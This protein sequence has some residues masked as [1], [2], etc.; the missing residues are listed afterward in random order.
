MEAAAR[1]MGYRAMK[2]GVD[3]RLYTKTTPDRIKALAPDAI[4]VA[5]GSEPAMP[6]I[7][8][9][10]L[11]HVYEARKVISGKVRIAAQKVAVIGGGL[12]GLEAA[13]FLAEQ[14][15]TVTVI[16]MLDAIGK[17]L[18]MY[19]YPHMMQ[20]IEDFH[21]DVHVQSKCISI[22]PGRITVEKDGVRK[23]IPADAVVIAAGAKP[24]PEEIFTMASRFT[25]ECHVIGDAKKPGNVINAIWQGHEA[26]RTI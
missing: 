14:G 17:D 6:N 7:P 4:I 20:I 21:I 11:E 5:V 25:K 12:V 13:E 18:E 10:E 24:D 16:E 9:I 3:V 15:K 2:A 23:D 8:G 19:I 22:V 1:Y 26:A